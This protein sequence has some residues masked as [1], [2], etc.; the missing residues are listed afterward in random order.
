M[1]HRPSADPLTDRRRIIL[2]LGFP[3]TGTTTIQAMLQA[4]AGTLGPGI[5]VSPKDDLT[6]QLRKNALRYMRSGGLWVWK[7]R[8][9]RALADMVRRLDAMDFNTLIISDENMI[10]IESGKI[11]D[12]PGRVDYAAWIARLDRALAGYDVVYVLYTRAIGPW[13]VSAYNQAFKMRRVNVS[14][15]DWSRVHDD[16]SG[17]DRIIAGLRAVVGE[18]LQVLDMADETAAGK[19]LGHRLLDL[20]GV[21]QDRIDAVTLPPRKNESLPQ[22]GVEF[23]RHVSETGQFGRRHYRDLVRL[24]SANR[25]LFAKDQPENR[26]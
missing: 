23:L 26:T 13:H 12:R 24:V 4:N 11:F 9:A 21:S 16:M 15:A 17:P 6:F 20:A 10:G 18:R 3:K 7:W 2:H 5:A 14:Y 1:T 8:H 19:I 22:A 25:H